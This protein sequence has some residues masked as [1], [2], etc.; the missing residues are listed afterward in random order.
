MKFSII[1]SK[2]FDALQTVQNV[3]GTKTT[4][5]ILQNALL[6]AENGHL[7]ITTTDLDIAE[8]SDV[9]CEIEV[10]GSTTLNI[11]RLSSIIRELGDEKIFVDVDENDCATVQCGSA[12]FKINGMSVRDFPP[13]PETEGT[14]S[15]TVEQGAFHE[16]LR[17][18]SYATSLDET[19]GVMNGLLLSFKDKK[20]TMVATDGRR[21]ALVEH[22]VE[23]PA[24][25]ES[26]LVLPQKVVAELMRILKSEG[27]MK[28]F[29][30]GNQVVFNLGSTVI[31]SKLIDAL[32]PNYRQV[33]PSGC[34]ERAV[35]DRELLLAAIRRVSVITTTDKAKS[36]MMTFSANQ[37]TI[38]TNAPD[39]GEARDTLAIK[40]AG[41][42]ISITF[43]PE[44]V[45]DPLKNIDDDEI[46]IEMN[47]GHNP[48]L[49][50]CSIPFLYVLMPLRINS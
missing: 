40:Y 35:I 5:Q 46:Y 9:E 43:N 26:D 3:V 15:F 28:I 37:L 17:K 22:E 48:A 13:I 44:F 42:E 12:Y 34:E 18:V 33:I 24:E 39:V 32:Y 21:L 20:L 2:F 45:M 36:M 23:F 19:R 31:S 16:M 11:R 29:P 6:K 7:Q 30:Q 50:K 4:L 8:K 1:R 41:K 25:A 10:P 49:M 47:D 38:S 27:N 14:K